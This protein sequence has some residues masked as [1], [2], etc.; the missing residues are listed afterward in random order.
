M[1]TFLNFSSLSLEYL[2]KNIHILNQEMI[3]RVCITDPGGRCCTG[4]E[5]LVSSNTN[6]IP[7]FV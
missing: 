5:N 6:A 4:L 3:D 1:T 2:N 7:G